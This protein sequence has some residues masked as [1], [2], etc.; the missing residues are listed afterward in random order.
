MAVAEGQTQWGPDKQKVL[1]SLNTNEQEGFKVA[2]SFSLD[3]NRNK[4]FARVGL[5]MA[6]S[7]PALQSSRT[8]DPDV[9]AW[10]G[11]DIA[12]GIFGDPAKGATQSKTSGYQ[13]LAIREQLSLP[14]KRGFNASMT[15]HQSRHYKQ[16]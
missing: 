15:L 7:D 5:A 10:L 9:R 1:A 3:R 2:V 11:F 6:Q 8:S 12:S 16:P 14:A 13:V 4:D